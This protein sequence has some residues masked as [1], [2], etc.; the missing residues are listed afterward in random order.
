[1]LEKNV[2]AR[3]Q[4]DPNVRSVGRPCP[5]VDIITICLHLGNSRSW[6]GCWESTVSPT[7]LPRLHDTFQDKDGHSPG[8][9]LQLFSSAPVQVHYYLAWEKPMIQKRHLTLTLQLAFIF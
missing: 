3:M 9:N 5:F 1:M 6:L 4:I 8:T 2:S 7:A